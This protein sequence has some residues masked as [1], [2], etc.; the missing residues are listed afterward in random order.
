MLMSILVYFFFLR[1]MIKMREIVNEDM[2]TGIRTITN[3]SLTCSGIIRKTKTEMFNPNAK[4]SVVDSITDDVENVIYD[5]IETGA[6]VDTTQNPDIYDKSITILKDGTKVYTFNTNI[7]IEFSETFLC[8]SETI[9]DKLF[10]I[11]HN[12]RDVTLAYVDFISI[13]KYDD[14]AR[15]KIFVNDEVIMDESLNDIMSDAPYILQYDF[16]E[17]YKQRSKWEIFIT[18]N[19]L[20]DSIGKVKLTFI[21]YPENVININ[22]YYGDGTTLTLTEDDQGGGS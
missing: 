16:L 6:I 1:G 10:Y 15:L 7:Q 19:T 4:D 2:M 17:L 22:Q 14:S 9:V 11:N 5:T 13:E 18:D 12:V 8:N 3:F 21:S 20:T